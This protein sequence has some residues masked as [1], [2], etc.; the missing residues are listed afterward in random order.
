MRFQ[1]VI[2]SNQ[3][4]F[5]D[6]ITRSTYH[7][8]AIEGNTLSYGET[9]AIL[10]NDNS[11]KVKTSPRELYEAINHKYALSYMLENLE[12]PL[13]KSFV[14][15]IASLVNKNI[16]EIDNYRKGSVFIRGAEHIPPLPNEVPQAMM[17]LMH[18]I[19]HTEY[20]NVFEKAASFHL[21]FERIH[22][23]SDG[24]GRTGRLLINYLLLKEDQVPIVIP[25]DDRVD[26]FELLANQDINRLSAFFKSLSDKENSIMQ[27]FEMSR[28]E[29][30]E[31]DKPQP[32]GKD[33]ETPAF[34]SDWKANMDQKRQDSNSGSSYV[35]DNNIDIEL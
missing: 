5:E 7:S 34:D 8:N 10:W 21:Q 27:R 9:Y 28:E 25:K 32:F 4:Y 23:F 3:E 17:Y 30:E 15:H 13:S 19:D 20:E 33:F 35:P 22:P 14:C 26:Y 12:L 6:F 31:S 18:N 1:D 24:N 11:F 29:I 16:D 2:K